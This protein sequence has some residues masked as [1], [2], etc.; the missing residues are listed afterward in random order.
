MRLRQWIVLAALGLFSLSFASRAVADDNG[1]CC[2]QAGASCIF[3]PGAP[4]CSEYSCLRI[5]APNLARLRDHH[6]YWWAPDKYIQEPPHG[7]VP[8]FG[9]FTKSACT[10]CSQSLP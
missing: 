5:L 4:C 10:N 7:K 9:W 1:A 3:K 6:V 8:H 2:S